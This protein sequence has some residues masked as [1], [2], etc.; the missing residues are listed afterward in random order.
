MTINGTCFCGDIKYK[1]EGKLRDATSCHCSMCRKMFGSQASAYAVLDSEDFSW[2]EGEK[3]LAVYEAGEEFGIQF[4]SQCGST[5]GGTYKGKQSWV[6]LGCID[7]DP[8]IKL[9]KHIFVD[10][11]AAW[12]IIPEGVHQYEA[13]PPENSQ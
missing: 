11:K 6:T 5:F 3:L 12:E 13:W 7:G 4:C 9:S 8:N 1:I 10:S 2:T